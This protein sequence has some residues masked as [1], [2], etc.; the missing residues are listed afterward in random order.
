VLIAV[1]VAASSPATATKPPEQLV[2]E[3][4]ERMIATLRAER[5]VLKENPGRIYELVREIAVPHFD[6]V[7]MAR[8]ALGSNWGVAD[9]QQRKR[10]VE[11]FQTLLVGTYATT[12]LQ[13]TDQVIRYFPVRGDPEA[14]TVTV[15]SEIEQR[16]GLNILVLYH[17]H[18]KS[19]VW[20]VYD[21]T[22]DGVS[23]VINYRT[24]FGKQIRRDGLEV[25]MEKLAARNRRRR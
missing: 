15:R 19:G 5:E 11:E 25:F 17:L 1:A 12:L 16:G 23:L 18:R 8:L 21:V 7:R 20:K 13:Y 3:T 6:F 22:T 24:S 14:A 4:S 10:F 9:A 2:V